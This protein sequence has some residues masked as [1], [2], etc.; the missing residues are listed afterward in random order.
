MSSSLRDRLDE[1]NL[2]SDE[3]KRLSDA[4]KKE[5][6]RKLFAEYAEEISNPENRALYEEEIRQLE[7]ER[8]MEVKFVRPEPGYVLKTTANGV[9]K[10]FINVCVS[11]HVGSPNSEKKVDLDGKKGLSWCIPHLFSQ[12]REDFAKDKKRCL[13]YDFVVH[14][15]TFR[16]AETNPRFRCM[17]NNLAIDGL[18][19]MFNVILDQKNCKQIKMKYKGPVTCSVIRSRIPGAELSQLEEGDLMSKFPYP[20]DD[21]SS[22]EKAKRIA[23]ENAIESVSN[24]LLEKDKLTVANDSS[25]YTKPKYELKHQSDVDLQNYFTCPNLAPNTRPQRLIIE[26]ILPLLSSA[27]SINLD[28]FENSIKLVSHKPAKYSLELPLPYSID[29][30]ASNAKF[31]KTK[32]MLTIVLAVLPNECLMPEICN[33]SLEKEPKS[34]IDMTSNE[35]TSNL[36]EVG[37]FACAHL[38]FIKYMPF[39]NLRKRI[40]SCVIYGRKHKFKKENLRLYLNN[41]VNIML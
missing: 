12:P 25:G 7:K 5:E 18:Q 13:V 8:G 15:S 17:I 20:Y 38:N 14:P 40:M 9:T 39:I 24:T 23:K 26:V 33:N 29:E 27:S 28:V 16:M 1:M 6:F 4:F 37:C 31:D 3:V 19:K 30:N 10:A 21:E 22:T 36:N 41:L 2:T 11:D 32:H 34:T 35:V